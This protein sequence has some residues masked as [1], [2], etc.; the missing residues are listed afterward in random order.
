MI[1]RRYEVSLERLCIGGGERRNLF[2]PSLPLLAQMWPANR[3]LD[4]P[5]IAKSI[6]SPFP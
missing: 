4:D 1:P 3:L 6:N 5:G 2:Q